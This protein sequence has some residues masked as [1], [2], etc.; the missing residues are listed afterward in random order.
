MRWDLQSEEEFNLLSAATTKNTIKG[1][2]H[3]YG[4]IYYTNIG[5]EDMTS[6]RNNFIDLKNKAYLS[7]GHKSLLISDKSITMSPVQLKLALKI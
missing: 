2:V 1:G 6:K 7:P 5:N 3:F 4:L